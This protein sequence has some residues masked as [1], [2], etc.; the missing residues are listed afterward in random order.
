MSDSNLS[1]FI[2]TVIDP[3]TKLEI[4]DLG[5][6]ALD[7]DWA[8]GLVYCDITGWFVTDDGCLGLMDDCGNIA[9]P[10]AG[11]FEIHWTNR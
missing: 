5:R 7:E 11:R 4:D 6:I 9:F 10:P 8:K 3:Q 1:P 2:F